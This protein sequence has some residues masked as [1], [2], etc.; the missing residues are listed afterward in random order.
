[1]TQASNLKS[2]AITNSDSLPVVENTTGE[3]APGYLREID[4]FV[5]ALTGDTTASTYR[6]IRVPTNAKVKALAISTAALSAST[7]LDVGLYYSDAPVGGVLDGT[8]PSLAGTL[9]SGQGTLFASAF[10][11]TT[12][13]DNVSIINQSGNN[14]IQLRNQPIWQTAGLASDPGGYFDIV[15]VPH[16]TVVA[17]G[18]IGL[19]ADYVD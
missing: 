14:G 7:T 17:G 10:A 11:A 4:G 5:T 2:A 1:M 8:P 12:A 13:N 3:G 19:K 16:V 6:V 15:V 9:V 18:I